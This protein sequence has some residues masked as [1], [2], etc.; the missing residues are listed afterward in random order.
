M[1]REDEMGNSFSQVGREKY[2]KGE[3]VGDVEYS[4]KETT[5]QKKEK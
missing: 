3:V 1:Y 4:T 2:K 5:I